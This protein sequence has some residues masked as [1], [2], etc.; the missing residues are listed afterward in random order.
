MAYLGNSPVLS[1]QEY[2]NIDNIS[3]SFN[4]V[5][6]SF[7]LLVNGVAPVPAPQSSNQC[8]ISVNGV[9]QKPDDT[10][11][12]GFRLSGGNIIFSSAPTGGQSFFGVI[13]AG[14]DYIYAGQNFP[15]GTVSA[16]SITFN[17]D[18]DTGFYRS[19]AG[20][21]KFTANGANAVT[22]SSNGL[23]ASNFVPSGSTIPTNGVYL[24]SANNVAIAT[25]STQRLLI[26]SSGQIEAVSLG[27]AAAPTWSFTT[28]P[29][30][31]IYSP[32][33]DQVA[34]STGGSGRLFVDASGRVGVGVSSPQSLFHVDGDATAIRVTRGSAIGF[35]YN[36]GTAATDSFRIQS[37]GGSVDLLSAASQPITLSAGGS[38]K[39]RIT[40]AGLV[41]VGTSSPS[42]NTEI[43]AAL[44]TGASL[45]LNE[46]QLSIGREANSG[47]A[48]RIGYDTT[49]N[50]G[51]ISSGRVGVSWDKLILNAGGGNVGIGTSSPAEL[52]HL[53]SGSGSDCFL[54][55][56]S[57][58]SANNSGIRW[59]SGGV[60]RGIIASDGAFGG[61]T[62]DF[63]ILAEAGL[64]FYTNG[65]TTKRMVLDT[66]GRVG[67]GSTPV[68][69]LDV[70]RSGFGNVAFFADDSASGLFIKTASG[71]AGLDSRNNTTALNFLIDG[72]EKARLDT[73]GRWLLGTSSTS[74]QT[75]ALFQGNS[76]G[77]STAEVF[78]AADT[79]A[80]GGGLGNI[81]FSDNSH[82]KAA[83]IAAVRDGGTWT[84]GS[85]QPTSLQF[86]TT[87]NGAS[88]PTE[89]LRIANNGQLSA[90]VPGNSTLYPGFLARAW[91][92]F[93]GTSASIG[94]GRASGNVSSV[95]DNGTGDYTINFSTAMPDTNYCVVTGMSGNAASSNGNEFYVS[96]Q[97]SGPSYNSGYTT[98]SSIRMLCMDGSGTNRDAAS[99]NLAVFR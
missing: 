22:F 43:N 7:A 97:V 18:L 72:S 88:S 52:V 86:Y 80:P 93:D 67:I 99:L 60:A 58:S 63:G 19:G 5:T 44:D 42:T 95:T 25:N 83:I 50:F 46:G 56:N 31:G 13:L 66:S 64:S 21:V 78:L 71:A 4:G 26:D 59:Q 73:S 77:T 91:I 32:G 29:N 92:N 49:N 14:A 6:T 16:P 20:E 15:D 8:L 12:T 33:A 87:V 45:G 55:L 94:A 35:A 69:R 62:A 2:R 1:Q 39:V 10:G 27:T 68:E 3:G 51:F 47:G 84:S 61:S 34:I 82:S 81:Y 11:A 90:V 38:E 30:T 74:A 89:R 98:T 65:T 37:N 48:I 40:S 17:Q 24:P 76:A 41:G 79:N 9:V 28:D 96:T 57:T 75:R 54:R 36:T 85:S 70:R 53:L 23:T